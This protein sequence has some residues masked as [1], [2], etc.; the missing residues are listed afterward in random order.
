MKFLIYPAVD[1]NELRAIQSVSSE[2]E[3][4]NVENDDQALEII[5]KSMPCTVE[6]PRSY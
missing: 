5:A 2:V 6:S 4:Q 1:E 3:V